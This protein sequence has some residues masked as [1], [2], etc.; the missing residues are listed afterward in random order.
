MFYHGSSASSEP[1]SRAVT[2]FLSALGKTNLSVFYHDNLNYVAPVGNTDIR[3]GNKYAATAN[4]KGQ[5]TRDIGSTV[6]VT[7]HGSFDGWYN[8]STGTPTILVELSS[9]QSVGKITDQV[10]AIKKLIADGDI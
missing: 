8:D 9:D 7:Q 5:G 6:T 10:N 3:V 1:E 2:G 4:M